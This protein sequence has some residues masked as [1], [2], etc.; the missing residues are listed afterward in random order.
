MTLN[1]LAW[2]CKDCK[3]I[4]GV[5]HSIGIKNKKNTGDNNDSL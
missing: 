1:D 2:I 5:N 4:T 3:N